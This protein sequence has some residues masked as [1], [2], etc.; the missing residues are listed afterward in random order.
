MGLSESLLR[1]RW[2]CGLLERRWQR[3]KS[4]GLLERLLGSTLAQMFLEHF[5]YGALYFGKMPKGG[6]V[7]AWPK[8]LDHFER[9]YIVE[10][11]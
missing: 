6:G 10:F 9:F 5:L 1:E 8:Y 3:C 4:V 11:H 2:G 7:N